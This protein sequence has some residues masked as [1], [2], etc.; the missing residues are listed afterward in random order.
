[1]F[2]YDLILVLGVILVL[3]VIDDSLDLDDL[4]W[5][6]HLHALSLVLLSLE[7][8]GSLEEVVGVVGGKGR[9]TVVGADFVGELRLLRLAIRC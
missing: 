7:L 5:H 9:A 8:R 3:L 1:M 6:R 2:I 4:A